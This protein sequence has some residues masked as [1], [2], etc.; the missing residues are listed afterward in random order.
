M[1]IRSNHAQH[2]QLGVG[3]AAQYGRHRRAQSRGDRLR[4]GR[5]R[6]TSSSRRSCGGWADGSGAP[7]RR[8]YAAR[9]LEQN[10]V[11][12]L[13]HHADHR[14]DTM[15]SQV[16]GV[17][18]RRTGLT[19]PPFRR[20]YREF[21]AP[22][23]LAEQAFTGKRT[24]DRGGRTTQPALSDDESGIVREHRARGGENTMKRDMNV[25]FGTLLAIACVALVACGGDGSGD[26]VA[27]QQT[28][29]EE[30]PGDPVG[31]RSARCDGRPHLAQRPHPARSEVLSA[32][33]QSPCPHCTRRGGP[34]SR[35]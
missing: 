25:L 21:R 2:V 6:S 4:A 20:W 32:L 9:D 13:R 11:G 12:P 28:A 18:E 33:L 3:H 31:A 16:A 19:A 23:R 26:K 1:R 7:S 17:L 8:I 35:T 14:G 34:S 10:A 30:R 29:R 24:T 5:R 22:S 27:P 15:P